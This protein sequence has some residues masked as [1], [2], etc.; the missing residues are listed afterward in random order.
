M[1]EA[2][3]SN[4]E[5]F[6]I[7]RLAGLLKRVDETV[8]IC[9]G[10]ELKKFGIS[11]E[12]CTAVTCIHFYD[13][14]AT[15][16]DIARWSSRKPSTITALIRRM[17]KQGLIT[18]TPD[19]VKK[20][21]VRIGL[22]DKGYQVYKQSFRSESIVDIFKVLPKNKR[23]VLWSLLQTVMDQAYKNLHTDNQPFDYE[24]FDRELSRLP[25]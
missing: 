17:E 15:Q 14:N 5:I 24:L 22:T 12:Q 6:E 21:T 18:K 11:A 3:L 1:K 4:K 19:P 13:N 20:N 2:E 9:R 25:K 10:N 7:R 8:R 23:D 16:N